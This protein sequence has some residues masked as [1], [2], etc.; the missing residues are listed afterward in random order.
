M[1]SNVPLQNNTSSVCCVLLEHLR[2]HP[3]SR[4]QH[5][6]VQWNKLV[7]I[8]GCSGGGG[9]ANA[10]LGSNNHLSL[11]VCSHFHMQ[12]MVEEVMTSMSSEGELDPRECDC[13]G[14]IVSPALEFKGQRIQ[15]ETVVMVT[16]EVHKGDETCWSCL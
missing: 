12:W 6:L 16:K 2:L 1:M 14:S 10:P 11:H 5:Q 4:P 13:Q 9:G 3:P 8:S 7:F 15:D